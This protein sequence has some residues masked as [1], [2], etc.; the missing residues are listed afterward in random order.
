M[1]QDKDMRFITKMHKEICQSII[2]A[3]GACSHIK[4][5]NCPFCSMNSIELIVGGHR[6]RTDLEDVPQSFWKQVP[7]MECLQHAKNLI[8]LS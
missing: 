3:N 8:K 4:C 2:D 7:L 1:E 5:I 6:Y